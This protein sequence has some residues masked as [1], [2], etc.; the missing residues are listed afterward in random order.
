MKFT[1]VYNLEPIGKSGKAN[2]SWNVIQISVP[3]K[4]AIEKDLLW[5]FI[6]QAL[7]AHG[8]AYHAED[9]TNVSVVMGCSSSGY[10]S[11]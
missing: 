4:F 6:S 2:M 11:N 7:K 3:K 9:I 5:D 1:A 10:V 8:F